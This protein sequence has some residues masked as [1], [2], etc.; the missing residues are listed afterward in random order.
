MIIKELGPLHVLL[1]LAYLAV[2][3]DFVLERLVGGSE[4]ALAVGLLWRSPSPCRRE[5]VRPSDQAL[6]L[7]VQI[8]HLRL[9]LSMQ[10]PVF[11]S[12]LTLVEV[13]AHLMRQMLTL[14]QRI[15]S[16]ERGVRENR[17]DLE[18]H[19]LIKRVY[20]LQARQVI[21][22]AFNMELKQFFGAISVFQLL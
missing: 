16:V 4:Q 10:T 15:P 13:Q 19:E 6:K 1:G 7:A 12:L 14:V 5:I 11:H 18:V 17:F 21:K 22:L 3:A 20:L 9:R 2:G 8:R